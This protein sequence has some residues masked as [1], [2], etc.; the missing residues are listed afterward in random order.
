MQKIFNKYYIYLGI[1]TILGA[2]QVIP[3]GYIEALTTG[4]WRSTESIST[5]AGPQEIIRT[6]TFSPEG[7]YRLV[8]EHPVSGTSV[9]EYLYTVGY[10]EPKHAFILHEINNPQAVVG[11]PVFI[12]FR[13]NF[14]TLITSTN[15]GMALA[16]RWTR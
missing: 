3:K 12:Q 4:S 14:Q 2:C 5:P 13:D 6:Q 15:S 7:N 9:I 10:Y 8:E 1:F 16:R 11:L